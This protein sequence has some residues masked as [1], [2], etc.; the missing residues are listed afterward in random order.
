[1]RSQEISRPVGL[2][3]QPQQQVGMVQ[4]KA[5]GVEEEKKNG[6]W[7]DLGTSNHI[8]NPYYFLRR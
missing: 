7:P 2:N 6:K 3:K 8:I 1:M 4:K 5:G